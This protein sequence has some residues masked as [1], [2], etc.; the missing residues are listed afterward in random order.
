MRA[1]V[2][3]VLM[4]FGGGGCGPKCRSDADCTSEQLNVC[5]YGNCD[6][7][8]CEEQLE[9]GLLVCDA[10]ANEVPS[11]DF[12]N[13]GIYSDPECVCADGFRDFGGGCENVHDVIAACCECLATHEFISSPCTE[14]AA[15][16]T[17]AL[18]R[19]AG[20]SVSDQ[21][22]HDICAGD[23]FFLSRAS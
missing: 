17:T 18:E 3:I 19:G 14:S 10:N 15:Q 6:S 22:A 16:C 2:V 23:C 11:C 8:L 12:P 5:R 7:P 1:L 21:C 20:I 9:S 13:S 4:A